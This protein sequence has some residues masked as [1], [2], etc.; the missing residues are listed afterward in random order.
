MKTST[1]HLFLSC[2]RWRRSECEST[3][4]CLNLMGEKLSSEM[5]RVGE[6]IFEKAGHRFNINS[7]KQL[8]DVLFNK[9]NLPKPLK[10][11]K[12][13]VV[14]TAQDVLEEL[15]AHHDVPKLVIEYRYLAKLKSNYVDSLPLLAD[16]T[17]A[18]IRPSTRW[19]RRREGCP[20]R[21]RICRIF[22]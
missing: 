9:M 20:R 22:R 6:E 11:G 16:A 5:Q 19:A 7:P 8:G 3:P 15:A 21:I 1:C 18:C 17:A 13:K 12:G 2:S 10:Y 4:A 14:S